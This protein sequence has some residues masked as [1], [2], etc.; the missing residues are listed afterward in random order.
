M[1]I[2]GHAASIPSEPVTKFVLFARPKSAA[3]AHRAALLGDAVFIRS[4]V[5]Y[6]SS[7]S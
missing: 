3:V 4:S 1:F 6:K 5:F 2:A 7:L